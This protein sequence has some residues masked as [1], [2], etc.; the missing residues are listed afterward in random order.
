[1]VRETFDINCV[2]SLCL[3]K[4]LQPSLLRAAAKGQIHIRDLAQEGLVNPK[5]VVMGSRMGSVGHNT[6]QGGGYAY[7]ASKA[8]LNAV[9]KSFSVDVLEVTWT[10]LHP[11]RVQTSLVSIREDGALSVEEAVADCARLIDK[12]EAQ[13][14]GTFL[15]RFGEAIP[16]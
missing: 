3:L 7:R 2:G 10:I 1:M 6:T 4:A 5:V 12:L 9:V 16:W 14:S 13:H 11:G 15:D 8:A